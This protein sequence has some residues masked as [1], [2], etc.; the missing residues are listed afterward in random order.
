MSGICGEIRFDRRRASVEA[1]RAMCGRMAGRGPDGEGVFAQGPIAVGHRRLRIKDL[2]ERSQQ[3][4]ID[5]GLGLGIVYDGAIYNY[6]ELRRD[7]EGKGCRFFSTSDAEV[8]LKA[9]HEWGEAFVERL[10]GMFAFALWERDT[11]R[12]VCARD[13]LGIK[14]FY[15]ARS[16]SVFRFAS[17]LPALLAAGGIDTEID[18]VA[19]H[20]YLSFYSVVPAPRTVLKGV[21]KLPPASVL[22]AEPDGRLRHHRY[23]DP[24]FDPV[25]GGA[26][27]GQARPEQGAGAKSFE[28]C[29]QV[30]Q[31]TLRAAVRRQLV[32]DVPVG[33]LLSGGLTSSLLVCLLTEA[34]QHGISTFSIG[35]EDEGEEGDKFRCADLVAERFA[36]DHHKIQV[37]PRRLLASLKNCV[38]AMSE[39]MAGHDCIGFFLLSEEVSKQV[40]VAQSGQ[41]ANEIFAGGHWYPALL[42][43][44]DPVADCVRVFFDRGHAE[45]ARAVHPRFV[46]RDHSREFVAAHFERPGA[47]RSIDKALRLD[48]TAILPEGAARRVDNMSMAWGL[49]ARLP[50]LDHTIVE[51]AS[52]IPAEFKAGEAGKDVL[53]EAARKLLPPEVIDRPGAHFPVAAMTRMRGEH[54]DFVREILQDPAAQRRE[55]FHRE[56]IEELLKEPEAHL[57]PLGGSKLWQVALL[58][59]W[60]SC[61]GL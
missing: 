40:K 39:P 8:L 56:Y 41:G 17:S 12:I 55:L 16:P 60:L 4:M 52:R 48:A 58:H 45:F 42:E 59:Y 26:H 11:G 32:A 2:S 51:T 37:K 44:A 24:V 10:S 13:R 49:E 34:G 22:I 30:V 20:H 15:W 47:R 53:K 25:Q 27:A 3:P 9:Y 7:L 18:P 6:P 46:D 19:L 29:Q 61:Q 23:W 28:E 35:F 1:V 57:T 54:L 33:V 50:L 21:R 36:T 38:R 31:D 5:S 43:S 14:P